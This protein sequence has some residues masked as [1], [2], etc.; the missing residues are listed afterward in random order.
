[1]ECTLMDSED[2]PAY[3]SIFG[4]KPYLVDGRHFSHNSRPRLWWFSREPTWPSGTILRPFSQ[5]MTVT[6]V[7]PR[8]SRLTLEECLEPGWWPCYLLQGL[9]CSAESFSFCCFT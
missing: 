2:R 4:V 7:V 8:V 1:M 3:D 9:P 5:D 6:E